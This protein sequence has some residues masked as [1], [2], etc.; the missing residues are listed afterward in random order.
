MLIL[1]NLQKIGKKEEGDKILSFPVEKIIPCP[2]PVAHCNA[3]MDSRYPG[4][5]FLDTL[6][7]ETLKTESL[8]IF[9]PS[10]K[11]EHVYQ[12]VVLFL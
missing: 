2:C 3:S 5:P 12:D 4:G 7:L 6:N 9:E 8:L 10:I 1:T 11:Y